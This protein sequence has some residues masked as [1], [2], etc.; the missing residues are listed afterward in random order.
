[1]LTNNPRKIEK[2]TEEG[3]TI[4]A[5]V[6]VLIRANPH[7]AGYLVAKAERMGHELSP[8]PPR[9]LPRSG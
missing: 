7:S 1:L 5:R 3:V 4:T 9:A 6:P 2:L 8:E